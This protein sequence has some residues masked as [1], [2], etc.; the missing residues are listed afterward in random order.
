MSVD[1]DHDDAHALTGKLD[2]LVAQGLGADP[3]GAADPHVLAVYETAEAVSRMLLHPGRARSV[4]CSCGDRFGERV[5]AGRFQ[6][7]GDSK[8]PFFCVVTCRMCGDNARF[9]AGECAGLIERDA[10]DGAE[11][12]E[13]GP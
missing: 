3:A 11:L 12:L 2:H 4:W 8:N 9:V 10:T 7:G 6:C 5:V 13:R 1:L